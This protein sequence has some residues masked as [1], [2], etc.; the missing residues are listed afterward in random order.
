[1]PERGAEVRAEAEEEEKRERERERERERRWAL[2]AFG[3]ESSSLPLSLLLFFCPGL[4][5]SLGHNSATACGLS[6]CSSCLRAFVVD[7]S[8]LV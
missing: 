7:R 3:L 6:L 5:A 2:E 8:A 1:V 4:R